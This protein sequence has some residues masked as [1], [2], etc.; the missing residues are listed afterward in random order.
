MSHALHIPADKGNV[1]SLSIRALKHENSLLD[2]VSWRAVT[3]AW[4]PVAVLHWEMQQHGKEE[5]EIFLKCEARGMQ[6]LTYLL[7][8]KS[9][10]NV[11]WWGYGKIAFFLC[12]ACT[13][14]MTVVCSGALQGADPAAGSSEGSSPECCLSFS[15]C[16]Q[17][18]S[19]RLTYRVIPLTTRDFRVSAH[20]HGGRLFSTSN[21]GLHSSN[22]RQQDTPMSKYINLDFLTLG[23]LCYSDWFKSVYWMKKKKRK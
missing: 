17:S 20:F 10:H 11:F 13:V 5:D 15:P 7:G 14:L 12:G 8:V 22:G 3:S 16:P 4:K 2:R 1:R 21:Y 9:T 6:T 19:T 18:R 23:C